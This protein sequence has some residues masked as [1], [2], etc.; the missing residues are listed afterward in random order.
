MQENN[1]NYYS[2]KKNITTLLKKFENKN[3]EL[4]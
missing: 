3:Y 4:T 1:P 2:T